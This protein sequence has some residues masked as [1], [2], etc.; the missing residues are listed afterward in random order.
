MKTRNI[1]LLAYDAFGG[2]IHG[3]TALQKKMYFLSVILN[4]DL[5]YKA[6]FYGPYSN[7]VSDSNL[8]LK[9]MGYL[10]ESVS[11]AGSFNSQGFEIARH[12]YQ[13]T[14]DGRKIVERKKKID[15]AL[16]EKIVQ[17]T[18]RIQS[19]GEKDYM[20]LAIA[21]KELFIMREQG[22]QAKLTEIEKLAP[23]FG[24]SVSLEKIKEASKYLEKIGLITLKVN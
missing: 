11:S 6:H 4:E 7:E 2:E 12:D 15:P 20:D 21:A 23:K 22:G 5:G 13:L 24:W 10:R 14:E 9:S 19:G 8:E 3:K 16:W 17:A 18:K 1:L